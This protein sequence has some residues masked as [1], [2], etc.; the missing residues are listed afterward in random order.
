MIKHL[1]EV[2]YTPRET[3]RNIWREACQSTVA[4][5]DEWRGLEENKLATLGNISHWHC[6]HIWALSEVI[7][8]E[9]LVLRSDV[10]VNDVE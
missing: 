6:L 8:R 2:S 5:S 1:H 9:K 3:T 4:G 10:T 7:E